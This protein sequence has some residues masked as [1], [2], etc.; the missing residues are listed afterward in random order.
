MADTGS[1]FTPEL[2]DFLRELDIN[3][4][5]DWF[6]PNKGR[7]E[8]VVRDSVL[9]F[10]ADVAP[11][12]R[13][14]SAHLVADPKPVGGSM[15]RI[16]RDTRLSRDKRP[17]KTAVKIAFKHS[18]VPRGQTDPGNFLELRPGGGWAAGGVYMAEPAG[19]NR[20]RDAIIADPAGWQSIKERPGFE[21]MFGAP[22]GA[23]KRVPA[24]YPADH[25]FA[26]DLRRR[27]FV[28]FRH[29]SETEVCASGF[30]DRYLDT[31]ELASPF[32]GFLARALG[33]EW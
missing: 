1:Y 22:K 19:L 4:N 24:P 10:V 9:A 25:E 3:N 13:R 2:F 32:N 15:F 5:R 16:Y 12:L 27:D 28:W 29:F 8:Q 30:M 21:P 11:G 18:E 20:I 31:C 7:Y 23:Y 14:I 6:L 17:Y 26:D 33:L